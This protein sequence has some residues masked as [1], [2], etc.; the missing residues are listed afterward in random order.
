MPA[1]VK[2]Q[3]VIV[4]RNNHRSYADARDLLREVS[5]ADKHRRFGFFVNAN[6]EAL[7][8]LLVAHGGQRKIVADAGPQTL[9]T[10]DV[11]AV[12]Q[13]MA[14]QLRTHLADPDV[15]DWLLPEFST[16]LPHDRA[17]ATMVFLGTMKEY[18][19]YD[20]VFGCGFPSV[21]LHGARDDS[22]DLLQR[23][24]RFSRF[25]DE[26]AAWSHRLVKALGYMVGS[27]GRPD[28]A[29][30]RAFWMRCCHSA[31]AEASGELVTMSGWV[32]AFCWWTADGDGVVYPVI[33]MEEIPT[34]I[35]KAPITWRN[36]DGEEVNTLFLAGLPVN[37][38]PAQLSIDESQNYDTQ[39]PDVGCV[40]AVC[41]SAVPGWPRRASPSP[42]RVDSHVSPPQGAR[43]KGRRGPEGDG[44]S[45]EDDSWC[46][47]RD[48]DHPA[49]S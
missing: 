17:T 9:D 42:S 44:V 28:N 31:G 7:R 21:T 45:I 36:N 5:Y 23:A 39:R 15:A 16:T 49:Q 47:L 46:P 27:F 22:A 1:V 40:R 37:G 8:P 12:A 4:G 19:S 32:A 29:D 14:A 20:V 43:G 2:P 6:A 18:F 34:G 30:M 41:R 10:V 26:P 38:F 48:P 24:G 33:T 35:T 13:R 25:G 11:D 3:P